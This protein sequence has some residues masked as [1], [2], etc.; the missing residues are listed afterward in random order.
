MRGAH[1]IVES[2][3]D[4]DESDFDEDF[5][6][7]DFDEYDEYDE[8]SSL[9]EDE[10]AQHAFEA[11]QGFLPPELGYDAMRDICHSMGMF[12]EGVQMFEEL[13]SVVWET[14]ALPRGDLEGRCRACEVC[15]LEFYDDMY[16]SPA[17]AEHALQQHR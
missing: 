2:S 13:M 15:G 3:E 9:D 8:I 14:G 1:Q 16:A 12:G 6:Y 4:S 17:A 11:L 10:R 7:S 5:D